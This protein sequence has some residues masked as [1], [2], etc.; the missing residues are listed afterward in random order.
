MRIAVLFL[1]VL[2]VCSN[3]VFSAVSHPV[4]N[5][6]IVVAMREEA[7]PIIK[8]LNLSPVSA[9]DPKLPMKAYV[10]HYA[11]IKIALILNGVDPMFGVQN[12]GSQP[13]VLAT[14]LGINYFHPDLVMS[15]GTA[16]G[17]PINGVNV[18]DIYISE[19]INFYSRRLHSPD[20]KLYGA[21]GYRSMDTTTMMKKLNIKSAIVCSGDSFDEDATDR[22][23]MKKQRCML[24]DMEAAGVNWVTMLSQIPMF[25]VK[26]VTN[27]IGR[28]TAHDEFEKNYATVTQKLATTTRAVLGYLSSQDQV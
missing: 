10:G 24:I 22:A 13:A 12:I 3:P 17:R 1:F 28:T 7:D 16:G 4:K 25:A 18:G 21:G 5:V 11:N 8:T 19:K 14:Y 9:P 26:G 20:Y 15:V 27:Y 2:T 23:V 6:L